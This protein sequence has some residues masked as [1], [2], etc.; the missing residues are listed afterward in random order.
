[1]SHWQFIKPQAT[2]NM[3]LNP[4]A[5]TT[6]NF[7]NYNGGVVTRVS[8][9]S[10][11]GLYSYEV[12]GA[13]ANR[14]GTFTLSAL[15][16]TIHYVSIRF[17]ADPYIGGVQI[18]LDAAPTW[19]N[20]CQPLTPLES[21]VW[22]T[23]YAEIPAAQANGSTTLTLR[24]N[25]IGTIEI[26]GIQVE[27][28]SEATTYCDGDQEG[29]YWNGIPHAS[30][31][32]RSGESRAGGYVRDFKDDYGL[33]Q[34][35][36]IGT[37]MPPLAVSVDPYALLPG[38]ELNNIKTQSRPFSLTGTLKGENCD[39][40][41]NVA[42]REL[43]EE[44]AHDTYP[45]DYDG[46]QP[47]R[48]RYD[49]VNLDD[50]CTAETRQIEAHYEQGLGANIQLENRIHEKLSLRF[51]APDPYWYEVGE[52]A[53]TLLTRTS[54][55]MR[56]ITG[57]L[58]STGL[59]DDLGLTANPTTNGNIY[60]I[61]HSPIDNMIYVGGDFIGMNGIGGRDYI[62][63]YNP[64]TDA[65][66]TVGAGGS[67]ND[68][69]RD[70]AIAPNGDV[71][72]GGDFLNCG[73]GGGDYVAYYDISGGVW[74]PVAAGG[75]G[76]VYTLSFGQDGTLYI[77]GTFINWSV[78]A[79]DGIVLWDGAA[80]AALGSGVAG[81]A[82]VRAS[83]I[84]LDG[85]LVIGGTFTT[86]GGVG[87]DKIAEWDGT[88][89]TEVGPGVNGNV[90]AL[91]V[92]RDTGMLYLSGAF[93]QD[94][95]GQ[96]LSYIASWNGITFA[97]LGSGLN[98][99]AWAL[100]VAPNSF[101]YAGGAFTSAGGITLAN[102]AAKWNGASWAHLDIELPGAPIVYAIAFSPAD[103]VIKSNYDVY[104]GFSTT[105]VAFSATANT[106]TND[107]TAPAFPRFIFHQVGG[108]TCRLIQI[109]NETTGKELLFDY[110]L[111]EGEELVI[112]LTPTEK[113]VVSNFFGKRFDAILA[114]SD[115]GEFSLQPG[116]N[117]V[118]VYIDVAGGI[119]LTRYCIWKD[120][121][122]SFD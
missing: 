108:T 25:F 6:G 64:Y 117:N 65:W 60:A 115:T 52:S 88:T 42:R 98:A 8:T 32:T 53:Q 28:Q 7:G 73:G 72:I 118:T 3:V 109:R 57:R 113:S 33:G 74:A 36:W 15:S 68:V 102:R 24:L 40:N 49:T 46:W 111:L 14:G 76:S 23:Y 122:K 79:G 51:I 106:V 82:Q 67:V 56:Y 1:M 45:K 19:H 18:A 4:S 83:E 12:T 100:A 70:I 39:C 81:G 89:W 2:T 86:V 61:A 99:T 29:C 103:P 90:Y 97:S 63:Q 119:T 38:G 95:D 44:L 59:W 21:G 92:D 91:A 110:D 87:C 34:A 104:L 77:G 22:T 11:Y 5:E 114:N 121:Y 105:G 55:G 58:K 75:T 16:N 41:I 48:L 107:G 62:A 9:Y 50:G 101:L 120:T 10:N 26:D 31:S 78:A 13:V 43:V 69:V 85:N 93:T 112:D 35:E 54:V 47:V 116:D 94:Q 37:G 80:Y 84:L 30:T 66:A 71:Y 20:I 17:R 96:S 27:A